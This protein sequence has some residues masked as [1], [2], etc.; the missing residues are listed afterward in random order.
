MKQN[1]L[2]SER[3][4]LRPMTDGDR[5]NYVL[6]VLRDNE[7]YIQYGCEP[8]AGLI[9]CIKKPTPGVIYY[10]LFEKETGAMVG[11][12]GITE[13]SDG[14]EFYTFK[15]YRNLGYCGE[16]LTVFMRSYLSGEMTGVPHESVIGETLFENEA[17]VRVLVKAGFE[18]EAF[19][20]R[21]YLSEDGE[22]DRGAAG[23]LRYR[24]TK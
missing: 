17:S 23:L 13:Q 7:I 3:L 20:M 19:G 14:L 10:S 21:I 4:I 8:D 6:H 11:Y 5:K 1:D 15:E 24:Y 18:K 22:S 2:T 16:A 12:I 9:E